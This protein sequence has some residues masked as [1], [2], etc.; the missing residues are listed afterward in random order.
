ML[1]VKMC[2]VWD[3]QLKVRACRGPWQTDHTYCLCV[4]VERLHWQCE[5][6]LWYGRQLP[7]CAEI[8]QQ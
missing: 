3:L 1:C 5:L 8:L 7:V 2:L 6:K 4:Q